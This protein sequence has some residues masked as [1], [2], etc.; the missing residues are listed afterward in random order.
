MFTFSTEI[1]FLSELY[2]EKEISF[3]EKETKAIC[4]LYGMYYTTE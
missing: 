4:Y 2:K 3:V 1:G